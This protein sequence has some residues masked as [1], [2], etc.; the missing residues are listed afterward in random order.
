MLVLILLL[1]ICT[2][3]CENI[4]RRMAPLTDDDK[5]E[6]I[7]K[8]KNAVCLFLRESIDEFSFLSSAKDLAK[9]GQKR[10]FTH[11]YHGLCRNLLFKNHYSI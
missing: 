11:S 7:D 5:R 1:D 4:S 8:Y 6:S 9:S 2:N 10:L 3:F